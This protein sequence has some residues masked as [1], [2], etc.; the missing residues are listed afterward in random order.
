[1]CAECRVAEA[2]RTAALDLLRDFG[3]VVSFP[4]D[5]SLSSLGV[6]NPSWVTRA[7]YPLLTS[8]EL[9][10]AGGLLRRRDLAR[11]LDDAKRYPR[12]KHPWLIDLMR[13]FELLF[14][15][16]SRLLLPARLPKDAPVWADDGKWGTP[17]T[18]RLELRYRVLPESV[19]SKFIVRWH[20]RAL[21]AGRWWRHGIAVQDSGGRCA[22]LV[23]AYLGAPGYIALRVHGPK[24]GAGSSLSGR[25][26]RRC[27]IWGRNLGGELWVVLDGVHPERVRRP[28]AAGACRRAAD[29][30]GCRTR[31]ARRASSTWWRRW[32]WS[33]RRHSS[34]KR[35]NGSPASRWT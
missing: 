24:E 29:Q 5:E 16:D 3:T 7:V 27:M 22:A 33:S 20:E 25:C 17:E 35:C 26:A 1:M 15:N 23:R 10:S 34:G 18:L 2:E 8:G 11:L 30:E 12:H 21:E 28:P 14:E 4:E 9:A 13:K 6:L 31:R 19:I 32:T